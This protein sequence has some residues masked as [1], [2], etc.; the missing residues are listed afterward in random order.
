M[1][2]RAYILDPVA[3]LLLH[4]YDDRGLDIIATSRVPLL[5]LY[6]RFGNWINRANLPT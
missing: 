4:M 1:R 3:E 6:R 5:P 2:G